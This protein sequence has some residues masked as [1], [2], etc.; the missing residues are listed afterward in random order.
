M[1]TENEKIL[2]FKMWPDSHGNPVIVS[3]KDFGGQFFSA[4]IEVGT[5]EV[6]CAEMV[7]MTQ[8]EIDDLPEHQGW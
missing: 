4:M 2:M 7:E 3:P 8:K 6:W 5:G 1:A